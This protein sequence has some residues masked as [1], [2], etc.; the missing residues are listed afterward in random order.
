MATRQWRPLALVSVV[1]IT[2]AGA[3]V[4]RA[5]FSGSGNETLA[6]LPTDEPGLTPTTESTAPT[7]TPSTT[8]IAGTTAEP[9]FVGTLNGIAI[10]PDARGRSAIE[11]C[12]PSGM[13]SPDPGT[14]ASVASAPGP[15]QIDPTRFP[16]GL[17]PQAIPEVF[18]CDGEPAQVLWIASIAA[19]T[20]NVNPGGGSV[21]VYRI[22]RIEP[23]RRTAPLANWQ[24]V[25]IDGAPGVLLTFPGR[26]NPAFPGCELTFHQPDTGVTTSVHASTANPAFCP[27]VAK[28]LFSPS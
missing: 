26:V 8:A 4:L 20:E 1:T 23:V 13:T 16:A 12:P 21:A 14:F 15:L 17:A 28:A 3:V 25:E 22:T 5:V 9:A 10:D 6:A 24:P 2:L 18:L 27:D 11:V 7:Q 19:G